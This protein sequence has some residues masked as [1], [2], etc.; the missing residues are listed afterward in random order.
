MFFSYNSKFIFPQLVYKDISSNISIKIVL[1]DLRTAFDHF[2]NRENNKDSYSLVYFFNFNHFLS[3]LPQI[4][5]HLRNYQKNY[6][7]PIQILVFTVV[8]GTELILDEF[9]KNGILDSIEKLKQQAGLKIIPVSDY[10]KHTIE[11]ATKKKD[12]LEKPI[13]HGID[14]RIYYYTTVPRLNKDSFIFLTVGTNRYRKNLPFL[15]DTFLETFQNY[16]DQK[17]KLVINTDMVDSLPIHPK[18]IY[19]K[20]LSKKDMGNLYRNSH[21]FVTATKC[22]GFGLPVLEAMACGTPV[23]SPY[24]SGIMS[25]CTHSELFLV[26]TYIEQIPKEYYKEISY[27]RGSWYSIDRD[28]L[29][30]N[31]LEVYETNPKENMKEFIGGLSCKILDRFSILNIVSQM[32]TDIGPVTKLVAKHISNYNYLDRVYNGTSLLDTTRFYL[33][34]FRY[35]EHKEEPLHIFKHT[36]RDIEIYKKYVELYGGSISNRLEDTS[37]NYIVLDF[38]YDSIDSYT[39]PNK[40]VIDHIHLLSGNLFKNRDLVYIQLDNVV[41]YKDNYIGPCKQLM[42][43]IETFEQIYKCQLVITEGTCRLYRVEK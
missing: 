22:E 23:I 17:V 18:L 10:V 40:V 37:Y 1:D 25:I 24:H 20:D 6:G 15:I 9:D 27:S 16:S 7:K 29:K 31:L 41:K 2:A 8:E 34:L 39:K 43:L 28:S 35:L 38:N 14:E 11:T 12:L 5:P 3:Y 36:Q 32:Y 13:Y 30:H 21:A 4:V 19:I 26:K 42:Y 33:K